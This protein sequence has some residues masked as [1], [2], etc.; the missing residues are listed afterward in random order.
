MNRYYWSGTIYDGKIAIPFTYSLAG[1]FSDGIAA[2]EINQQYII[3][4]DKIGHNCDN[5]ENRE[6]NCI[7]NDIFS[8]IAN[9]NK[10]I[11]FIGATNFINK[12]D[13]ELKSDRR[14][15]QVKVEFPTGK[16]QVSIITYLLHKIKYISFPKLVVI[17][18]LTKHK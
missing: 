6:E 18:L 2:V 9:E 1:P 8:V 10:N 13:P 15:I 3:F 12:I 4:I 16:A 7:I 17:L 11:L 14:L 5:I